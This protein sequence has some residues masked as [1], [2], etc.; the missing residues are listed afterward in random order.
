MCRKKYTSIQIY[1]LKIS[2]IWNG[3]S[4]LHD[5]SAREHLKFNQ[6]LLEV[7]WIEARGLI[8]IDGTISGTRL[9]VSVICYSRVVD[10]R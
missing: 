2:F 8:C 6:L 9:C 3:F 4:I 1:L 5:K 7:L 10:C